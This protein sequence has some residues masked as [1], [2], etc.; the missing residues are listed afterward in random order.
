M[1]LSPYA[2]S[3]VRTVVPVIVGYLLALGVRLGVELPA[4]AL[5]A[6]LEPVCVAIYYA[7]ARALEE[8]VS[9]EF[10]RLLGK[11]AIVSYDSTPKA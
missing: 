6:L 3:L 8:K 10:G 7:V 4:D 11:R 9:P 2:T 1:N 5:T